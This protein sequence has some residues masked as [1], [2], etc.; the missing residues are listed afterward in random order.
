M[1]VL[2]GV[3]LSNLYILALLALSSYFEKM[4]WLSDE[5]TRKLIHIGASNYWFL[6]MAFFDCAMSA[7]IVPSMFVLVNFVAH[8]KKCF[9]SMLRGNDILDLG[10]VYYAVA[11]FVLSIWTFG[12]GKPEIGGIGILIMGYADG[13]AALVGKRFGKHPIVNREAINGKAINDKTVEGT[14]TSALMAALVVVGFN[15]TF[16]M[17]LTLV[18]TFSIVSYAVIAELFTPRG[19]DN[20]T[21]PIGCSVLTY[22]LTIC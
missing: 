10:P 6:A 13:M 19:I 2:I 22:L 4:K 14:L 21:V 15:L 1:N 3:I 5:G 20:L 9:K 18:A 11:M 7:A 12:I 16:D 17:G 8:E